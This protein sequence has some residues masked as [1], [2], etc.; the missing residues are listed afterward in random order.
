MFFSLQKCTSN[1]PE[2]QTTAKCYGLY[3]I[4]INFYLLSISKLNYVEL[5]LT[6]ICI[7]VK[8]KDIS[9]TSKII[10]FCNGRQVDRNIFLLV[11]QP[12]ICIIW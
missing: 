2:I 11:F 3:I 9:F 7:L 6:K 1:V 12:S 5:F 8:N 4:E 10:K